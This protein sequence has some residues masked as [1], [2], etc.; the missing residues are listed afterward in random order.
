MVDQ[1][2]LVS[3]PASGLAL[4]RPHSAPLSLCAIVLVLWMSMGASDIVAQFVETS[5]RAQFLVRDVKSYTSMV[6]ARDVTADTSN[7]LWVATGGGIYTVNRETGE[8]LQFRNTE[9][10]LSLDITCISY[11]PK[12]NA[13]YAGTF[14]GYVEVYYPSTSKWVHITDIQS[15]G[16]LY[17][18]RSIHHIAFKGDTAFI[19]TDFGIALY[20]IQRNVFIETVDRI[21]NLDQKTTVWKVLLS[22][23]SIIAA[24][25][26]GVFSAPLS[27]ATLRLPEV[28]RRLPALASDSLKSCKDLCRSAS[29]VLVACTPAGVYEQTSDT[30]RL[31]LAREA[32]AKPFTSVVAVGDSVYYAATDRIGTLGS[33]NVQRDF[34]S[35]INGI[36]TIVSS[37]QTQ[38]A[39]LY[40]TR[41][42]GLYPTPKSTY[43]PNSMYSNRV[44]RVCVDAGGNVWTA[45]SNRSTDG[46]GVSCFDG[47]TWKNANRTLI[48][49]FASDVV[50]RISATEDSSVWGG[51]WGDGLLELSV[52]G[53]SI[54]TNQYT[55]ANSL[56][57]GISGSS[58]FVLS[59]DAASDRNGGTWIL[60]FDPTGGSG[61]LF[62]ERTKEKSW[63]S[64]ANQSG[65]GRNYY[66]MAIDAADTKWA[67]GPEGLVWFN[68]RSQ[69]AQWGRV[70]TSNSSLADNDISSLAVDKNGMLWIGTNASGISVMSFPA[71]V[72]RPTGAAPSI[73]RLRLLRDQ[74]IN[75]IL[76]DPQNNKWIATNSGVW[77]LA[78]DGSDTIG[79]INR[80]RYPAL[81]SDEIRSLALDEA[82]GTVYI[83]TTQGLN[84]AQTLAIQPADAF[85]LKVYPQPFRP[86]IDQQLVIDGLEADTRVKITTLEGVLVRSL[87]TSSRRMLWDGR[88]DQGAIV[89]SGVYL[90]LV[91]S[92]SNTT[93]AVSKI[94]VVRE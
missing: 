48:S 58:S 25:D 1:S 27:T 63:K 3:A 6:N 86:M 43:V 28:W 64:Y 92:Q 18:R 53:D 17:P 5:P 65:S 56:L 16:E 80:K 4:H 89:N 49:G 72:L 83:G 31:V 85:A 82:T 69:G 66:M 8:N 59:A 29:G 13:V 9:G 22:A 79:Y 81:L 7:T 51:T 47:T 60:N 67:A 30:F 87:E 34:P 15:S 11:L 54:K 91:V 61:P 23:D 26:G 76:I 93:T 77:I 57:T 46:Q 20:D 90:V 19:S 71:L 40:F 55:A 21:A 10:L 73:S 42:V 12:T 35:V 62:V 2:V 45:T 84:S 94:L 68:A 41:G 50:W 74:V 24:T 70:T 44:Q 75:D 38:V 14:D 52:Q 36:T 78:D 33:T 39:V 32:N 88:D 37:N